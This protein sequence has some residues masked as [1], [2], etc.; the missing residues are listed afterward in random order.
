M[1][2]HLGTAAVDS[3]FC[4]LSNIPHNYLSHF[5]IGGGD[6][7]PYSSDLEYLE[8]NFQLIEILGKALQ[9]E[10]SNDD[11]SFFRDQRKPEAVARE[12]KAKARSLRAKISQKMEATRKLEGDFR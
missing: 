11:T 2:D 5:S 6:S 7:Q 1:G 10:A 4:P 3:L 9:V 12:M 8:D